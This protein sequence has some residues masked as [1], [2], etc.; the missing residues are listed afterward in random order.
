MERTLRH[1]VGP[2]K[3]FRTPGRPPPCPECGSE[4]FAC[5]DGRVE[6]VYCPECPLWGYLPEDAEGGAE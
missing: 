4:R 6:D 5:R 3:D 2:R 1:S